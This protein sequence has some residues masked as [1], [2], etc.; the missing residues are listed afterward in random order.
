MK[1]TPMVVSVIALIFSMSGGALAAQRYL[2]TNVNQ[3]KPSV[4]RALERRLNPNPRV[5]ASL[6][7]PAGATGPEGK[8]STVPGP[9]GVPGIGESIAGPPGL[10]GTEGLRG[11]TGLEGPPG[12]AFAQVREYESTSTPLAPSEHRTEGIEARCPEGSRPIGG[13]YEAS[14]QY[15]H[16]YASAPAGDWGWDASAINESPALE[17]T[18]T[19]SVFCAG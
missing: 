1:R 6:G 16:V 15:I 18:V 19:V 11:P 12:S 5:G 8:A 4:L 7:A 13:G 2:L 10:Q 17:G 3:I 14:D 9:Q